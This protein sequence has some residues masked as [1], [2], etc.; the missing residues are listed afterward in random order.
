MRSGALILTAAAFLSCGGQAQ[1][2]TWAEWFHWAGDIARQAGV[3]IRNPQSCPPGFAAYYQRSDH[4]I[5]LCPGARQRGPAYLAEA[6]A[7]E[8]MHAAQHC[9]GVR[10]GAP[11]PIAL[12]PLVA[13]D[14]GD[15]GLLEMANN[16]IRAKN[17]GVR[18]ST[19]RHPQSVMEEAE[20]YAME[21]HPTL[22]L[23]YLQVACR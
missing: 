5:T 23:Q 2:R 10:T 12:G 21:D 4:S 19:R 8:A 13:A 14:T 3:T 22:A 11:G 18:F 15:T 16:A 1:A 9:A 20:A 6:L 7:H 17:D